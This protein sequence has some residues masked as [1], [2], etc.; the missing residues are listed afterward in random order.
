MDYKIFLKFG[1]ILLLSGCNSDED[2]TAG[3]ADTALIFDNRMIVSCNAP[4]NISLQQSIETLTELGVDVIF[5]SCAR[6]TN[7]SMT[8][9]CFD[10]TG[11]FFIHEIRERN[12]VNLENT[13]FRSVDNLED[14]AFPDRYIIGEGG[15]SYSAVS[16]SQ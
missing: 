12:L 8:E 13:N 10:L 5:S 2:V 11:E 3:T 6:L 7:I 15:V 14:F 4:T 1:F 16:C 9:A